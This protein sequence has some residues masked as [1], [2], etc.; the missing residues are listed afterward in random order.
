LFDITPDGR[1]IGPVDA[2]Q[3]QT[4]TPDAPRIHVVF[5]WTEELKARV[6]PR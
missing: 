6:P 3:S 4:G 1:I 2:E 5:N